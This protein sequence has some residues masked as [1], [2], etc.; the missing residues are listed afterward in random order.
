MRCGHRGA[1]LLLRLLYDHRQ[2]QSN[3]RDLYNSTTVAALLSSPDRKKPYRSVILTRSHALSLRPL[4]RYDSNISRRS[5]GICWPCSRSRASTCRSLVRRSLRRPLL[6][7]ALAAR[8]LRVVSSSAEPM[9]LLPCCLYRTVA[10]GSA[11]AAPNVAESR[12]I[13]RSCISASSGICSARL[14]MLR[15][16]MAVQPVTRF[17]PRTRCSR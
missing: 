1:Y 8:P 16:I 5:G 6:S 4:C 11:S 3:D 14:H 13:Q 9:T 17:S 7:R 12:Q 10:R 15:L 2:S